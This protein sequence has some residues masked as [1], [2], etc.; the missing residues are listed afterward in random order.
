M[1]LS[2]T[3]GCFTGTPKRTLGDVEVRPWGGVLYGVYAVG[4]WVRDVV[5]ASKRGV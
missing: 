3:M 1:L 5:D 4:I 2:G